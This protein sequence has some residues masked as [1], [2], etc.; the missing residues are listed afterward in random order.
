M[1]FDKSLNY[2]SDQELKDPF[3]VLQEYCGQ[4]QL[5]RR[6]LFVLDVVHRTIIDDGPEDTLYKLTQMRQLLRLIEACY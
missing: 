2:L 6:E 4:S 1:G 3:I 5:L